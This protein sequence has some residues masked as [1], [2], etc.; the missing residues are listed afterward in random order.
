[1]KTVR[2]IL[3]CALL[4]AAAVVGIETALLIREATRVVAALPQQI[5]LTRDSLTAEVAA[6]RHGLN[7]QLE[8]A[9]TDVLNRSERQADRLRVDLF[10]Q[11]DAIRATADRRL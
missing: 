2:Q 1:M 4:S 11:T 3:T 8:A 5:T 9:R 7:T 6:T 10:S